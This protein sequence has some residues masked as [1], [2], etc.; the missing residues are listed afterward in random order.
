MAISNESNKIFQPEQH[1]EH[2]DGVTYLP[3]KWRLAWLRHDQ[4]QAQVFTR[5]ISHENGLAVF[6]AR[7]K[8]PAGGIA[9]GWGAS[10]RSNELDTSG[11]NE[12]DLAYIIE[13]ENMALERALTVLGYGTEY[14]F[15]FDSPIENEGIALN[16]VTLPTP[17]I[18]PPQHAS[19]V[20]TT[21][22]SYRENSTIADNRNSYQASKLTETDE[23]SQEEPEEETREEPKPEPSNIRTVNRPPSNVTPLPTPASNRGGLTNTP[24]PLN[25]PTPI[26]PTPPTAVVPGANSIGSQ[27]INERLKGIDDSAL[28]MVIKQIYTEA[29]RLH[30]MDEDKVDRSSNRS[31]NR[32]VY[33]LTLEE[34]E[35][36]LEKVKNAVRKN[37]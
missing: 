30:G 19:N 17:A 32:P 31:Y 28:R 34:A 12:P 9:T 37:Q 13:A 24:R 1:L 33:E 10:A 27:A 3:L 14:A 18:E 22:P 6:Q 16:V 23:S 2:R 21:P 26:T 35:E 36:Y 7:I 20:T 15:D 25:R 8:V 11:D 29:R 5:L 4:P